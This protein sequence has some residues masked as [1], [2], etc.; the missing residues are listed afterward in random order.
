[1]NQQLNERCHVI[2]HSHA[3]AAAAGNLIPVP[4]LGIAADITAMTSM[5]MSLASV[6]GRNISE[7]VA[8]GLAIAALKNTI[9]KQPI[10]VLSKE[11]S[12]FVPFVGQLI[13]PAI[14]VAILES[15][16]WSMVNNLDLALP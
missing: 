3:A 4:G 6:M 1:M 8:K 11:I 10:R 15:A 16:G 5:C 13:A 12:K 14:S 9:L 7:E 2:I